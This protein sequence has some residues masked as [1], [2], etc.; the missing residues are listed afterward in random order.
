MTWTGHQRGRDRAA[1]DESHDPIE[2]GGEKG[3]GVERE[4]KGEEESRRR[5][6]RGMKEKRRGIERGE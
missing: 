6:K 5:G 1:R 4:R 2:G 3:E